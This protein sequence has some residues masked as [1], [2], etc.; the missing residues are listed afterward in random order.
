MQV[1]AFASA[2]IDT[3]DASIFVRF[4]GSGP[5]LL[6]LHGFPQTHLMWRDVAPALARNFTVVCADLRGYGQS[7]CPPSAPDHAPYSKRAMAKDAVAVMEKLGFRAFSVAGHDR[8]ARV[9][10]RLALDSPD[11]VRRVAVLDIVPTADAWDRADSRFALSFWPW[12]VLAQASPFPEQLLTHAPEAIV[13]HALSAWG[14]SAATFPPEVR[15]AY[16]SSIRAPD[17]AHAICE[18]YRA[19]S[20]LDLAHDRADLDAGNRI[21]CPLLALWSADSPVD[22]WYEAEGGPLSLWRRW[23]TDVRGR[24]MQGGHFFPEARPDETGEALVQF[25]TGFDPGSREASA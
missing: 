9:A 7:S 14:T 1:E 13:D 4:A 3:G 23:A 8:G 16:V 10:Y 20:T 15:R 12:S 11:R 5:P 24:R 18:E 2:H 6:L 17:R 21:R 22:T 25:L 19:A